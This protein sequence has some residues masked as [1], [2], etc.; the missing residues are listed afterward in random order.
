MFKIVNTDILTK[1]SSSEIDVLK[2]IDNNKK[3]VLGMSIQELSKETY[4]ST[5]TIMRLCKKMGLSGFSELKYRI[6]E[7]INLEKNNSIERTS[8]N[9]IIDNTMFELIQSSNLI[10]KNSIEK[11]VELLLSNKNIHFFGKGL[12]STAFKY[13]SKQLL[14]CNR[15]NI[16]YEDTHIA[17]L[18]AERMTKNDV[19]FVASL[20]GKTK[21]I[22]NM[23]QIAKSKGA[24]IIAL[25]NID[26][27]II[28]EL[29][30]IN[31]YVYAQDDEESEYDMKSRMPILLILNIIVRYYVEYQ[32]DIKNSFEE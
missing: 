15:L 4:I 17:Y 31:F 26:S 32:K 21:Q 11:V 1:L 19:L 12:T 18:A 2:Y 8:L 20:S 29:A 25:T 23:V 10:D 22:V 3:I 14:T 9:K 28:A 30:D 5:A 6:R 24:T 16:C 7:R 27:N 13:I